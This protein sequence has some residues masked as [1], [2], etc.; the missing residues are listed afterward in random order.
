[1]KKVI[2]FSLLPLLCLSSCGQETFSYTSINDLTKDYLLFRNSTDDVFG[3]TTNADEII[4]RAKKGEG[5]LFVYFSDTCSNCTIAKTTYKEAIRPYDLDVSVILNQT[6][7]EAEKIN[8]YIAKNS[9]EKRLI[10]PVMSGATPSMYLLN[11]KVLTEVAYGTEGSQEK[12]TKKITNTLKA[13]TSVTTIYRT[14]NAS[15]MKDLTYFYNSSNEAQIDFFYDIV[16][17]KALNSELEVSFFDISILTE[18]ELGALS[19]EISTSVEGGLIYNKKTKESGF[20]N[21]QAGI[22]LLTKYFD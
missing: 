2:L 6:S 5:V 14:E 10:N 21:T 12:D 16:Y 17:P 8:E 3:R 13:Y 19:T 15:S 18:S 20:Y 1:M 11:N 7:K 22:N 9:I 4:Y